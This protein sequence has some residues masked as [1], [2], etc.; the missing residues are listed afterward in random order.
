MDAATRDLA[1]RTGGY[2]SEH[3]NYPVEDWVAAVVNEDTRQGYWEWVKAKLD[4]AG[5]DS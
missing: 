5:G 3:P 1:D 4:D 2:W